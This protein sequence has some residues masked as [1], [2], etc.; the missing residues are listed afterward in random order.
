MFLLLYTEL[1]DKTGP[2]MSQG[3]DFVQQ[4]YEALHP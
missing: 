4:I 1:G 2:T 3:V